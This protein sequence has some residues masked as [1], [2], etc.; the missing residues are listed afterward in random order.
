MH[1]I[2][3]YIYMYIYIH[4]YIYMCKNM[5]TMRRPQWPDLGP[6]H[7]SHGLLHHLV[8]V[9]LNTLPKSQIAEMWY[10]F[11]FFFVWLEPQKPEEINEATGQEIEPVLTEIP[12]HFFLNTKICNPWASLILQ[13]PSWPIGSAI[14]STAPASVAPPLSWPT[15]W[16]PCCGAW[17]GNDLYDLCRFEHQIF[18]DPFCVSFC[19]FV[20]FVFLLCFFV[21]CR[22][23]PLRSF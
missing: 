11:Q 21:S 23:V 19:F 3:I 9:L 12:V 6:M 4:I 15:L 2:S 17:R 1:N 13:M 16:P 18:S 22:F 5:S 7:G 8:L 10:I 14:T 20:S